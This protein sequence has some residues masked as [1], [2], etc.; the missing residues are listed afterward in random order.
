[1][2]VSAWRGA[3]ADE[4]AWL[5]GFF[6]TLIDRPTRY[7]YPPPADAATS[8]ASLLSGYPVPAV[9]DVERSARDAGL[10]RALYA[11]QLGQWLTWCNGLGPDPLVGVQCAHVEF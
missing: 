5:V 11:L 8:L 6:A 3:P 9:Q 1:M 10:T 2:L 7:V 4:V